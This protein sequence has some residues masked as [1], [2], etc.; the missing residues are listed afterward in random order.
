MKRTKI[1]CTLG[2]ATDNEEVLRDLFYNGMNVARLNFSHGSHEEHKMR[3][4][5]FKRIR[6][7][8]RFPVGL[9]LDTKGPE[10]RIKT[11]K[12]GNIELKEG[13]EFN[14]VSKD[15]VGDENNVSITYKNLYKD[16]KIGDKILIDDGLVGLIIEDKSSKR[17]KCRVLND[18]G[19]SD[20]KSINIPGVS[21]KLPYMSEQDKKDILFGIENDFDF[22]AASFVRNSSD[23]KMLKQFIIKKMVQQQYFMDYHLFYGHL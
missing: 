1:I 3:V 7:D 6:E 19:V 15:I 18:G 8:L 17:I 13:Q 5:S 12:N 11:F 23:L 20:K 9:L 4:D 22:I 14:F 2:P 21:I 10:I 16:I